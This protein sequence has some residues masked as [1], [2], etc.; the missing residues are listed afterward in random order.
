MADFLG[1]LNAVHEVYMLSMA[2]ALSVANVDESSGPLG[3]AD[4]KSMVSED[5]MKGMNNADDMMA[6]IGVI[7]IVEVPSVDTMMDGGYALNVMIEVCAVD[8]VCSVHVARSTVIV[9]M[10]ESMDIVN[11][12]KRK[13]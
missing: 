10:A 2:D 11:V 7:K 4:T 3:V 5:Y 6:V 13:G 1:A 9:K 12:I 8:V